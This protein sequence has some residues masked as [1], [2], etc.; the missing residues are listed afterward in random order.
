[1]DLSLFYS[2]HF[3]IYS[4]IHNLQNHLVQNIL[5][6]CDEK[7][8]KEFDNMFDVDVIK[9]KDKAIFTKKFPI[10]KGVSLSGYVT[11]MTCDGEKCLPP[12]DVPF[13]LKF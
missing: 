5:K 11:Y 4:V 2:C 1:M 13:D 12:T 7:A 6:Q 3:L 8:I 10:K 9:F